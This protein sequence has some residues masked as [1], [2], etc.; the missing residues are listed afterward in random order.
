[1]RNDNREQETKGC[2]M[3]TAE[4][5]SQVQFP[6][7]FICGPSGYVA[8][9]D[10]TGHL[11]TTGG[12]GG[13]AFSAITGGTNT[14]ALVVGSGGSLSVTGTGTIG[15]TSAP[16]SGLTSVLANGQVIPYGDA[17]ISRTAAGTLAI[18]NGTA[19]DV[20]GNLTAATLYVGGP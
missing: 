15:A 7:V 18:G 20:T 1:M 19:G 13:G 14:A 3:P 5:I 12:G 16:W 6:K 4:T 2:T 11:L 17:G 8:D 10:S 9:V